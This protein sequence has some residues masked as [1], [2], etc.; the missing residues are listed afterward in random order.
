MKELERK[1]DLF[2]TASAANSKQMQS[3]EIPICLPLSTVDDLRE[4]E[5][6]VGKEKK[7]NSIFITF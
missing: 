2:I 6:W 3:T 1:L 7:N 4:I 5:E